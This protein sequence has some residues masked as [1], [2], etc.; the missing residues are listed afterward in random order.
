MPKILRT[1][2]VALVQISLLLL[3]NSS[4]LAAGPDLCAVAVQALND[5]RAIRKL[6]PRR[7]VPCKVAEK[8]AIEGFIQ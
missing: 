4:A 2:F 5:A 1:S 3:A 8:T 7:A 6:E